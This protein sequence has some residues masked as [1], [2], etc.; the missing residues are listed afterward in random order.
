MNAQATKHDDEFEPKFTIIKSIR[1]VLLILSA[2]ILIVCVFGLFLSVFG[3]ASFNSSGGYS[4]TLSTPSDF[5]VSVILPV[6]L[7]STVLLALPWENENIAIRQIGPISLERKIEGQARE[8]EVELA[9]I[10]NEIQEIRKSISIAANGKSQET[11]GTKHSLS[12]SGGTLNSRPAF[13]E[14]MLLDFLGEF[15]KWAFSPVRIKRYGGKQ[16]G[17]EKLSDPKVTVSHIRAVLRQLVL[18][19]KL[20]TRVSKKGNTLYRTPN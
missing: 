2:I 13:L 15:D 6:S 14:K 12:G 16:K 5:G 10:Q 7:I 1:I 11:I 3:G 8:Q 4:V 9:E 17:F 19:R 20:V 18:Q